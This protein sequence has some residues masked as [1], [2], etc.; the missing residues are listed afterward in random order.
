MLD[1][2]LLL[3]GRR[4]DPGRCLPHADVLRRAFVLAPLAE[5]APRL[6]HPLTGQPYAHAWKVL[7]ARGA[8]GV[9]RVGTLRT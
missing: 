5:L 2:D 9:T 7:A 3:Y 8:C 1:L 4:V 6:E